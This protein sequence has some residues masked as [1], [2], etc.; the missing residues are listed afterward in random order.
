VTSPIR[1]VAI[2][3]VLGCVTTMPLEAV[4]RSFVVSSVSDLAEPADPPPPSPLDPLDPRLRSMLRPD[5]T[6]HLDLVGVPAA[7]LPHRRGGK[8][9]RI[10]EEAAAW[11]Q[12]GVFLSQGQG[13]TAV[14]TGKD[15]QTD[16]SLP[17]GISTT[18][19]APTLVPPDACL[20]SAPGH[21][22][23]PSDAMTIHGHG[24]FD[25]CEG[26]WRSFKYMDATFKSTYVRIY[27]GEERF[28]V[29]IIQSGGTWYG[30]LFNFNTTSW[31][32]QAST[33]L[34]RSSIG[35]NAYEAYNLELDGCPAMPTIR[36][37]PVQ[38]YTASGGWHLLQSSAE[39]ATYQGSPD[40]APCSPAY[41]QLQTNASFYDWQSRHNVPNI[42]LPW[43]GGTQY[44]VTQ[45]PGGGTSHYQ[46]PNLYAW[47]FNL[48]RS[49]HDV[50]AAAA[51]TVVDMKMDNTTEGGCSSSY[52]GKEN[53]IVVD[54]GNGRSSIYAHLLGSSQY[55][56]V[57]SPVTRGQP[58][59]KANSSGHV[60]PDPPAGDHLH[61]HVFT[62]GDGT[63]NS[64]SITFDDV[65]GGTPAVGPVITSGNWRQ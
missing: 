15:A 20:E 31:E 18:L 5:T 59:A 19:Y 23:G 65:V 26:V 52:L 41:Y 10:P 4:A 48:S 43:P 39:A 47:D 58:L 14:Y 1:L 12:F 21:F 11:T 6:R 9:R 50:V 25:L 28:F 17:P 29:E 22:R 30:L 55:V 57:S 54:H 46:Q 40:V 44:R 63:K 53:F 2:F 42:L 32:T 13:I 7:N 27:D 60:C 37:A 33:T 16:L 61:Y 35:W 38:V 51:G 34:T 45:G 64:L 24:F 49:S 62:T 36:S 3:V 56:S 8:E